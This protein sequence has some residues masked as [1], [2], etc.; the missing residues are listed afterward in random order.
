MQRCILDA[1]LNR[2]CIQGGNNP[3]PYGKDVTVKSGNNLLMCRLKEKSR[4]QPELSNSLEQKD[5]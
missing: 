3:L 5:K 1:N 4:Q 2:F